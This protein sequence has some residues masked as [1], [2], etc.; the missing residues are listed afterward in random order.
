MTDANGRIERFDRATCREFSMA[1]EDALQDVA[2]EFGVNVEMGN[3]SFQGTSYT[4]KVVASVIASDGSVLS[5]DAT[6]FKRM[7]TMYGLR[8]DDLGSIFQSRGEEYV[9]TGMRPRSRKYPVMVERV[10][11]G[12][13]FKF[14]APVV[15]TALAQGEGGRI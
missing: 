2:K 12:K 14:S 3:G 7:A 9:V 1:V 15:A 13:A 5:P 6:A 8:E 10:K 11:D 4:L